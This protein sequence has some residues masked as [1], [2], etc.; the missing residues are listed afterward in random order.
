MLNRN[1]KE[2]TWR[3]S[4]ELHKRLVRFG[5]EEKQSATKGGIVPEGMIKRGASLHRNYVNQTEIGTA[6]LKALRGEVRLPHLSLTL[7][8]SSFYVT[9]PAVLFDR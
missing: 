9:R 3:S 8:D 2:K 5:A 6:P 4:V 1:L 7:D